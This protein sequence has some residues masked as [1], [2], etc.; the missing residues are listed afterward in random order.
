MHKLLFA[1]FSLT[2]SRDDE[3]RGHGGDGEIQRRRSQAGHLHLRGR[4]GFGFQGL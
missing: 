3:K 4:R 2:P 1:V